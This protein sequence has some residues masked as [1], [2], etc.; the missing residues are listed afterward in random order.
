MK[1]YKKEETKHKFNKGEVMKSLQLKIILIILV[2]SLIGSLSGCGFNDQDK[3]VKMLQV[4][5]TLDIKK[6][7]DV[8][9]RIANEK[10]TKYYYRLWYSAFTY[11]EYY[12]TTGTDNKIIAIWSYSNH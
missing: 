8:E 11:T 3:Y 2:V 6:L 4:G 5:E 1:D 9:I 12:I 10:I 7:E